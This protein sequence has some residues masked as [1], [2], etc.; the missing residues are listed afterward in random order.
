M[1]SPSFKKATRS[2]QPVAAVQIDWTNPLTQGL[3]SSSVHPLLPDAVSGNVWQNS[4]NRNTA[5]LNQ[6]LVLLPG[7]STPVPSLTVSGLPIGNSPRSMSLRMG[8]TS[9]ATEHIAGYGINSTNALWLFGQYNGQTGLL[10][11]QNDLIVS[12]Y[13]DGIQHTWTITHDGAT[14]TIFVDG[15]FIASAAKTYTT[16]NST[17]GFGGHTDA[18]N[19]QYYNSNALISNLSV[20]NRALSPS[21]VA[22]HASNPAQLYAKRKVL[23]S[24]DAVATTRA[25]TGQSSSVTPGTVGSNVTLALTGQSVASAQGT[26]SYSSNVARALSGQ[27]IASATGALSGAIANALT[28]A[29]AT[30]TTGAVSVAQSYG[31]LGQPATSATGTLTGTISNALTG[32]SAATSQG[33]VSAGAAIS[34]ALNGSPLAASTG[35]MLS[36]IASPLAGISATSAQGNVSAGADVFKAV[37]GSAATSATGSISAAIVLPMIGNSVA[38]TQGTLSP[39]PDVVKSISGQVAVT[40]QGSASSSVSHQLLGSGIAVS[41]GAIVTALGQA[42]AGQSVSLSAGTLSLLLSAGLTNQQI[43]LIQGTFA[44]N[45]AVTRGLT[46]ASIGTTLGSIGFNTGLEYPLAGTHQSFPLEGQSQQYPLAG[47]I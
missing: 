42:L 34:R 44:I 16:G 21:E 26:V 47:R 2:R 6:E 19:A 41:T 30:A 5:P 31:L 11:F 15:I 20:W 14:T 4:K 8:L 12:G 1:V 3:V 24:V 32:K 27:P 40:S 28:N 43:T 17:L 46:G 22:K 23:R 10:A 29:S 36:T 7:A 45:G 37:T 25:L 18:A 13:T 35:A 9:I 39:S 33:S 38:V